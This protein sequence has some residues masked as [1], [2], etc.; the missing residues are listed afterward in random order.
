MAHLFLLLLGLKSVMYT[1]SVSESFAVGI[2]LKVCLNKRV[3]IF[4]ML[5][6]ANL[7]EY[8]QNPSFSPLSPR[9]TCD[10]FQA[11][12]HAFGSLLTSLT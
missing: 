6:M 8:W 4:S 5:I 11:R 1:W 7:L 10:T 12:N 9:R 3:K 2:F